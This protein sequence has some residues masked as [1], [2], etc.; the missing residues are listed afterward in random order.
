[1]AN[2]TGKNN[3]THALT[4]TA[5]DSDGKTYVF[6]QSITIIGYPDRTNPYISASGK[7]NSTATSGKMTLSVT[8]ADSNSGV[9]SVT[10]Y[11]TNNSSNTT[12]HYTYTN[13]NYP[14]SWDVKHTFKTSKSGV[15]YNYYVVIKDKAGNSYQS[16]SVT[17]VK[18]K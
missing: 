12:Y 1:M 17:S 6:K 9:A 14:K 11:Y 2:A 3:G 13:S 4:A 8:A 16:G 10:F 5:T 18:S 7:L 15:T